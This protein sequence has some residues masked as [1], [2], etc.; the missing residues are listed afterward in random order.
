MTLRTGLRF[1]Q[2]AKETRG[3]HI[4]SI[5]QDSLEKVRKKLAEKRKVK[6][7]QSVSGGINR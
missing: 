2:K 1:V 3:K 6:D 4:Y 5:L 7:K